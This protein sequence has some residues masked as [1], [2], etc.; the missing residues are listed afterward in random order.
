MKLKKIFNLSAGAASEIAQTGI[1][2][3][4]LS[5]GLKVFLTIFIIITV[6]T[7]V[8]LAFHNRIKEWLKKKKADFPNNRCSDSLVFAFPKAFGPPGMTY[9]KNKAYCEAAIINETHAKNITPILEIIEAQH[10]TMQGVLHYVQNTKKFFYH[11]RTGIETEAR[12]VY[13]KLYHTYKRLAFVFRVFLRIFYRTFAIFQD[14]FE[15][16]KFSMWTLSSFWN[17]FIG[18]TFRDIGLL[19]TCCFGEETIVKIK[20][21]NKKFNVK[22]NDIKIND[23]IEKDIVIGTCKFINNEEMY[24]L[25][26]IFVTGSHLVKLEDKFIFVKDHPKAIKIDYQKKY[27]YCLITKFSKIKLDD[28][29]FTDYQ[30]DYTLD[31]YLKYIKLINKN[32]LLKNNKYFGNNL[33]RYKNN[34]ISL[35]PGFCKGSYVKTQKGTIF[36]DDLEIGDYI[37]GKKVI[38]IINYIIDGIV[39]TYKYE[40]GD[41]KGLLVGIQLFLIN[42]EYEMVEQNQRWVLGKLDCIGV[43][44]EDSL[45]KVGNMEFADFQIVGKNKEEASKLFINN[46]Q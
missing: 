42:G 38:G 30:E 15:I 20:R 36:V 9:A 46:L 26:N 16:L 6:I 21:D 39:Y 3:N 7:I 35:Y 4:K 23:I 32:N 5:T 2:P 33:E 28:Y 12:D 22:F 40:E 44:T 41:E 27:I 37:N 14:L 13:L 19:A 1:N 43:L 34:A 45:V 18:H 25:D 11:I 10:N 29:I 8:I 24:K 17:S 31:L